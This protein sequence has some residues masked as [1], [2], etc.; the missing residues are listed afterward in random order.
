MSK[1][2]EIH[3][4]FELDFYPEP[5]YRVINEMIDKINEL[6]QDLNSLQQEK[7]GKK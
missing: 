1:I 4:R 3:T 5:Q 6:V 7:E 2:E